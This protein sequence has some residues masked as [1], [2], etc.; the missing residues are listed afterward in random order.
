MKP[1][2]KHY[3]LVSDLYEFQRF[4][5]LT[6]LKGID[7]IETWDIDHMQGLFAKIDDDTY[8][9]Q[10]M[11]SNEFVDWIFNFMFRKKVVAYGNESSPVRLHKGFYTSYLL[12][13]DKI[14]SLIKGHNPKKLII[15]GQSLGAALQTLNVL[16]VQYNFPNIK[17]VSFNTGSPRVGNSDFAA[18]FNR[19]IKDHVTI[20]N[21]MDIV[22]SVPPKWFDFTHVRGLVHENNRGLWYPLRGILDHLWPRYKKILENMA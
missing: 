16:D 6:D 11:G 14:H 15:F 3:K 4:S 8:Y 2:K 19:R 17:L 7:I 18:S 22:T 13:R 1:K 9:I 21:G 5:T 10:H 20:K 12:I